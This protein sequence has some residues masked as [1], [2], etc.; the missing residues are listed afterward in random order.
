SV[1]LGYDAG[2]LPG[3]DVL[4]E[5]VVVSV[6]GLE[7]EPAVTLR[8]ENRRVTRLAPDRRVDDDGP[9]LGRQVRHLTGG[10]DEGPGGVVGPGGVD[11]R[12]AQRAEHRTKG[13]GVPSRAD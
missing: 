7:R 4:G 6:H 3:G 13:L 10:A 8:V 9:R 11:D 5:V 1:L 12:P 2:G